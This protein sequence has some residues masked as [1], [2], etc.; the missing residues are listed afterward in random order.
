MLTF[1]PATSLFSGPL[2]LT[3]AS[4]LRSY[5]RRSAALDLRLLG[6]F[7]LFASPVFQIWSL[8]LVVPIEYEK[9]MSAATEEQ[10]KKMRKIVE[11]FMSRPDCGTCRE[12]ER[13]VVLCELPC[14]VFRG[15]P[16][17][18]NDST[19]CLI[20]LLSFL[21]SFRTLSGTGALERNGVDGLSR[22]HQESNG[23]GN[24]PETAQGGQLLQ[25]SVSSRRRRASRMEQL[26]YVIV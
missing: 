25:E 10:W 8:L 15:S 26:Q 3:F 14:L 18:T 13:V 9:T 6:D 16:Q 20:L 12:R 21:S 2:S 4:S 7:E 23:L 24:D 22:H 1:H 5:R 11:D 17:K 19:A